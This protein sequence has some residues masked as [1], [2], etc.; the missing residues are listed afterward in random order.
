[1][2]PR[3]DEEDSATLDKAVDIIRHRAKNPD[4]LAARVLIKVLRDFSGD[5]QAGRRPV[6]R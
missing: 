6:R 3:S 1:M 2:R 5:V 4:K